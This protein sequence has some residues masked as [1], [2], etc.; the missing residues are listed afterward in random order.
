MEPVM[1]LPIFI[2]SVVLISLSGVMAPGPVFAVTV[3]KGYESKKAGALIALGHGVIEFPL[4][5]LLYLGLSEFFRSVHVQ[6]TVSFVGGI[7]LIFLGFQMF[8]NRGKIGL[9]PQSSGYTSL[10]AGF[11]ATTANPY[12]FLWWATVGATLVLNAS[13]FGYLGIVLFA[14]VHW[15]CDLVWDTFVSIT[16]FK[17]RR[18]W[19]QKVFDVIFAFCFAVLAVFGVW[20]IASALLW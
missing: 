6:K 1:D 9:K 2:A 12:F 5:F 16:V 8:R 3:A 10:V 11:I 19:T 13:M 17:S 15:S 7:V 20:F 4:I 18:L 14:V